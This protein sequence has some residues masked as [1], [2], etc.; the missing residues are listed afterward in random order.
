MLSTARVATLPEGGIFKSERTES[1]MEPLCPADQTALTGLEVLGRNLQSCPRC[2]GTF[3]SAGDLAALCR[4]APSSLKLEPARTGA[5][6]C[7]SCGQK[8]CLARAEGQELEACPSCSGVWLGQGGLRRLMA[9]ASQPAPDRRRSHQAW[10]GSLLGLCLGLGLLSLGLGQ[11]Q[12]ARLSEQAEQAWQLRDGVALRQLADRIGSSESRKLARARG[13]YLDQDFVACL[14]ELTGLSSDPARSLETLAEEGWMGQVAWPGKLVGSLSVDLDQDTDHELLRVIEPG[15]GEVGL[16]VEALRR[17]RRVYKLAPIELVKSDGKPLV[18]PDPTLKLLEIRS[19]RVTEHKD[20]LL[21][22]E[23]EEGE[24][25]LDLITATREKL[26][27]YRFLSDSP[28]RVKDG[29]ITTSQ[30]KYVFQ[31]DHFVRE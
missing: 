6:S 20:A 2:G 24:H 3:L 8:L 18:K 23:L 29:G 28:V 1:G 30:G 7:P 26:L 25:A 10:L 11:F 31:D 27:R 15:Q 17:Q 13:F 19:E 22:L 9:A 5:S 21:F 16:K 12:Q 14:N 4:L